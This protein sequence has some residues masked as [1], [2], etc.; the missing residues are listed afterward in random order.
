MD[1]KGTGSELL[2]IRTLLRSHEN[3][4]WQQRSRSK[5]LEGY[6][7]RDDSSAS[8]AP[9]GLPC[10]PSTRTEQRK[11]EKAQSDKLLRSSSVR[12]CG[13]PLWGALLGTGMAGALRTRSRCFPC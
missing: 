4:F 12:V 8:E 11:C 10:R 13:R 7:E 2:I 9:V 3:E 5:T 6:D 1:Q